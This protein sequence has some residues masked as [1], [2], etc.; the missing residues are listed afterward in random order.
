MLLTER[1]KQYR[2]VL[3]GGVCVH[4]ASVFDAMSARMAESLGF[5]VGMFA[6]SIASGTVLGAPDLV[7]YL[8]S[9]GVPEWTHTLDV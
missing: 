5:E 7:E 9:R 3:E 8:A 4:P 2:R 6:G 1:R